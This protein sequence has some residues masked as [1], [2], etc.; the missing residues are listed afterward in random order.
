MKLNERNGRKPTWLGEGR[1][2]VEGEGFGE[3]AG[4]DLL[5]PGKELGFYSK[6]PDLGSAHHHAGS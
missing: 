5:S 4:S 6:W 1:E 2:S 3:R